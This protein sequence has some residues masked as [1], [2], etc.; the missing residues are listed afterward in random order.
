MIKADKLNRY[1]VPFGLLLVIL[2]LALFQDIASMGLRYQADVLVSGQL[3]RLWSGHWVHLGWVHML[4]NALG[5]ILL[6]GIFPQTLDN[7]GWLLLLIIGAPAISFCLLIGLPGLHWY[8]GL[9]G[10]LH[11]AYVVGVV[12]WCSSHWGARHLGLAAVAGFGLIAKLWCEWQEPLAGLT[13][14]W[15]GGMVVTEAHRY[16]SAIGL[17][18]GLMNNYLT[19]FRGE[20]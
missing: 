5:L 20:A 14:D 15:I 3:W 9:S 19:E 8:V 16:G 11:A 18:L 1:M 6:T 13:A 7:R 17:L 12:G 10:I 4:G 2:F